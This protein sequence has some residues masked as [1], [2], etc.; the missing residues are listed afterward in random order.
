MGG[1]YTRVYRE[2]YTQRGYNP[3]YTGKVN[4]QGGYNPGYTGRYIPTQGGYNPGIQG[5]IPP[6]EVITRVY[7]R[8]YH[9]ERL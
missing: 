8:I 5:Y 4:T 1:I 9:P 2:I 3:G 6:R 7:G